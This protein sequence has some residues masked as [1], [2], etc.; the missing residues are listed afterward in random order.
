MGSS[1]PGGPAARTQP[2]FYLPIVFW[3]GCLLLAFGLITREGTPILGG[4]LVMAWGLFLAAV[5]HWAKRAR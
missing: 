3:L 4:A 5:A 2:R 1:D